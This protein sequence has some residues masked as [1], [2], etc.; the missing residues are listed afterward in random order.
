GGGGYEVGSLVLPTP[1]HTGDFLL[2]AQSPQSSYPIH[3]RSLYASGDANARFYIPPLMQNP[4]YANASFTLS[5][6]GPAPVVYIEAP[7]AFRGTSGTS[8]V[9]GA[10]TLWQSV[11][12]R[13]TPF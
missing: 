9:L 2:I 13:V 6:C 7:L 1:P 11:S 3:L 10:W 8:T 12:A 4:D 5:G